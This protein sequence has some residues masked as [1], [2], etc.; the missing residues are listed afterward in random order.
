MS[1]SLDLSTMYK[2]LNRKIGDFNDLDNDCS[3]PFCTLEEKSE[4]KW[5]I[6]G[7]LGQTTEKK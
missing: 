1:N 7:E 3:I 6:C 4:S 2:N 5:R